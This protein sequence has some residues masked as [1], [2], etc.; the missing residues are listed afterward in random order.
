MIEFIATI[1]A[2]GIFL[3]AFLL[4]IGGGPPYANKLPEALVRILAD[5][6][7]GALRAAVQLV[8]AVF[9]AVVQF[10]FDRPRR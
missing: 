5:A 4:V 8:L 7:V 1:L 2:L 10:I 9:G 3:Y 6:I